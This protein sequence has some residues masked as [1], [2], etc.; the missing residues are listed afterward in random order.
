MSTYETLTSIPDLSAVMR[1][2]VAGMVPGIGTRH[3]ADADPTSRIEVTGVTIDPAALAD[4]TRATSLRY[5]NS[6]PP[7]YFFV[8]GFPLT[9]ELMSRADFPFAP[10]GSVHVANELT[11][12]RAAR[13]DE[14][15]T[16][17]AHAENLR[18]HRRGLLVDII[19]EV[20]AD[21][22]GEPVW[23]QKATMLGQGASFAKTAPVALATRGVDHARPLTQAEALE[24]PGVAA[25]AQ[26]VLSRDTVRAYVA[27]S[28]D[29]NPIH[30]SNLGAK[31]FG[32]P[33]VIAHGMLSAATVLRLLEG[34]LDRPLRYTV[35][36]HKPVIVPA[37]IAAWA[38]Y[39]D[40]ATTNL[41]LRS[42]SK[43][44]KLHLNADVEFLS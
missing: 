33:G 18:P 23:T 41:Q 24:V 35:E 4:Y 13:I 3:V 43:P 34:T 29:S 20:T 30:T 7:T 37:R 44:E 26:W 32:F 38:L 27:A 16:F 9:M 6:L 39:A 22:S 40:T 28:G 8:L 19:T 17:R 5:G 21:G 12:T 14:T 25:N 11:Q 42:A 31:A 15:F 36:F 10:V 2:I 1:R